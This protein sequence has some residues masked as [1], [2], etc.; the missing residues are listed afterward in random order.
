MTSVPGQRASEHPSLGQWLIVMVLVLIV[1][2]LHF[3]TLREGHQWGDDFAQYIQQALNIATGRPFAESGYVYNP[4]YQVIGPRA[5]PPGFPMLLAP[6]VKLAGIDLRSLK[7][8]GIICFGFALLA[9]FRLQ[10]R[11]LPFGYCLAVIAALGV[12][13]FLWG[14]KD[15][16]LSDVPFLCF[17]FVALALIQ[18]CEA[19]QW[20]S[21][22]RTIAAGIAIYACYALRTVGGI[23]LPAL[24]VY[25]LLRFRRI[26]R[27][28]W[29][30]LITAG[31]LM[32]IHFAATRSASLSYLD[33]FPRQPVVFLHAMYS[34]AIA[35][36][37][38]LCFGFFPV[39]GGKWP[40][41]LF[42]LLL[43]S[44]GFWGYITRLRTGPTILEVFAAFY[45]VLVLSLPWAAGRYLI[46]LIP[47]FLMYIGCAVQSLP[48]GGK[49]SYRTV[50][51]VV[52]AGVLAGSAVTGAAAMNSGP[53]RES[54]A[55]SDFM[56]ACAFF[57]RSTPTDAVI[58]FNKPRLCALITGRR[59]SGYVPKASDE[60]LL[61]WFNDCGAR[62]VLTSPL[63]D[64]RETLLPLI[65]RHRDLFRLLFQSGDFKVYEIISAS[66]GA[67]R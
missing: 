39:W 56:A 23:L 31:S 61:Q 26:P 62:Y 51:A 58:I 67:P 47:L 1:A 43:V 48:G 64:E 55:N 45:V 3:A 49:W 33:D 29:I 8:V 34:H 12:N 19:Y 4:H 18:E 11:I 15:H 66:S 16:I 59:S 7:T 53:I 52:L 17:S 57:K 40:S 60:K 20:L 36:F 38:A 44:I 30:V 50:A 41:V 42:F 63:P 46:P 2:S 6:V 65:E 13:P 9:I 54:F 35:Y 21:A 10:F 28:V 32:A 37:W 24:V 22:R 5:Y 14:L 27:G 25:A